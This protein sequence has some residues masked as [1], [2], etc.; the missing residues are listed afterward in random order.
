MA[1][2]ETIAVA[3][4][5]TKHIRGTA[6]YEIIKLVYQPSN[7][8]TKGPQIIAFRNITHHISW[9]FAAP[10][11]YHI[12]PNCCSRSSAKQSWTKNGAKQH[13]VYHGGEGG[14]RGGRWAS[15]EAD[16]EGGEEKKGWRVGGGREV[17][18]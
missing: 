7:P 15:G 10:W 18:R 4:V 9:S 6:A 14:A 13:M 1:P 17:E 16:E 11:F 5:K 3:A 8:V 2:S 12:F